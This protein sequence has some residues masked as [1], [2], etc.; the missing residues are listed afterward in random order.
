MICLVGGGGRQLA[1]TALLSVF[2]ANRDV[3]RNAYNDRLHVLNHGSFAG[4]GGKS[5]VGI[6]V[7]ERC[8]RVLMDLCGR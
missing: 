8:M 3:E 5:F 4:Y 2:K 1:F 6:I 7:L